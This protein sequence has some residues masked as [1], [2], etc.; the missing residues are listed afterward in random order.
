MV[1]DTKLHRPLF[2]QYKIP[3]LPLHSQTDNVG[4]ERYKKS[5]IRTEALCEWILI[6][7]LTQRDMADMII[8]SKFCVEKL[9]GD[10]RRFKIRYLSL[11][12][13]PCSLL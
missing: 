13:L 10:I 2:H 12:R 5:H 11:K 3:T 8:Y 9:R 7:F 1:K 4:K 6:K